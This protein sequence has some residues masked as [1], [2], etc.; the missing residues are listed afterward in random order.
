M[1]RV[2]FILHRAS[3][4]LFSNSFWTKKK[5]TLLHLHRLKHLLSQKMYTKT[6][7]TLLNIMTD[8]HANNS[9][10]Y[11]CETLSRTKRQDQACSGIHSIKLIL[12]DVLSV[13]CFP[14]LDFN[15]AI[16][17]NTSI[18]FFSLSHLFLLE[19]SMYHKSHENGIE[20]A[21]VRW[22]LRSHVHSV[23]RRCNV[24]PSDKCSFAQYALWLG[25]FC[26]AR[27]LEVRSTY[28]R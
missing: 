6:F 14:Q 13:N 9:N 2:F 18:F 5:S 16:H 25:C 28:V 4:S 19:K 24:S 1:T 3:S 15:Y 11:F 23:V 8:L 12:N 17:H 10:F 20:I 22:N 21:L 27:S 26:W 7:K